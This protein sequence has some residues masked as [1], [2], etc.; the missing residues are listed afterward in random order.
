VVRTGIIAALLFTLFSSEGC[1]TYSSYQ[2]AR[3]V[4]RGHPH[5]TVGISRSV[6]LDTDEHDSE[7]NWWSIDGDMRFGIARRIDGSVRVSV[8]HNVPEGWGGG[9]I[10]VDLRGGVIEDHLAIVLPATVTLGD[11]YFYTFRIQPGFIGTIPLGEHLEI[12]GS[13]RA[14]VYVRVM[15]LF[16]IGYNLGL[17]IT[18]P[19]GEWTIRPE[20]GW[21]RLA[22]TD[23]DLA[24]FQYG[25]GIEH[26]FVVAKNDET[27]NMYDRTLDSL[28]DH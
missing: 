7:V 1:L 8:F 5:A 26:N 10:S 17:G 27:E 4:E 14:Y 25:V 22:G 3:I 28:V 13:V 18:T 20:V 21:L 15:E 24:Y 16:G 12:N 11:F 23:S 9:Q 2:S 19:S 6:S